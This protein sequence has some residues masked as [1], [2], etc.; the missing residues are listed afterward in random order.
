M[1]FLKVGSNKITD[2]F[3]ITEMRFLG[4][5]LLMVALAKLLRHAD[6]AHKILALLP[7]TRVQESFGL[8]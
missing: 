2:K 3:H 8:S 7:V 6:R 4:A 5:K 1:F